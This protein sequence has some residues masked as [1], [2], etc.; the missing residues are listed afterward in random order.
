VSLRLCVGFFVPLQF[1]PVLFQRDLHKLCAGPDA[2]F[3]EQVAERRLYSAL[4]DADTRGDIPVIQ[5]LQD[6][7]EQDPVAVAQ[8]RFGGG[9]GAIHGS[10]YGAEVLLFQADLTA[11]NLANCLTESFGRLLFVQNASHL[12]VP[13]VDPFD[14]A[15][16]P[17]MGKPT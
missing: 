4:G 1:I 6:E 8:L 7:S 10:K 13:G 9:A 11:R 17:V 12:V 16:R 5:T 3:V 2:K 15:D 14:A